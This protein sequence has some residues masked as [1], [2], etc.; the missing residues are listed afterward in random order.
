M[1]LKQ[2]LTMAQNQPV[3]TGSTTAEGIS[4]SKEY[5]KS[6]I[7]DILASDCLFCG[8]VMINTIDKTFIENWERVDSDWQ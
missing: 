5:L 1:N 8:E 6:Q 2:Q 3:D 7:E 4:N